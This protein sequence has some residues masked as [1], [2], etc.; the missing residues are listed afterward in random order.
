[1]PDHATQLVGGA[2]TIAGGEIGAL[3]GWFRL[4]AEGHDPARIALVPD[5]DGS[6][7]HQAGL[8]FDRLSEGLVGGDQ[9]HGFPAWCEA[10]GCLI[11]QPG[12]VDRSP[13]A[14]VQ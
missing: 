6:L 1:V 13:E 10:A 3:A 9:Q 4:S 12:E 8:C 7:D 5:H 14:G 11:E 2:S